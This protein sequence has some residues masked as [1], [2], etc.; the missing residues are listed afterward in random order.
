VLGTDFDRF[1]EPTRED[2]HA[3]YLT[4]IA[5]YR[6]GAGYHVPGEFVVGIAHR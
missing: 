2:A 5:P 4:S 1:D 3:E 6:R